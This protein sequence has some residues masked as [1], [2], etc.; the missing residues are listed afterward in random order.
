MEDEK[1]EVSKEVAKPKE[2]EKR[3]N[4]VEIVTEKGIAVQ[5]TKT[6]K[7][8]D[9]TELLVELLNKMDNIEIA[10]FQK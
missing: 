4:V 8:L 10:I 2:V 3:Y 7:I 1:V 6:E 9:N 5:D